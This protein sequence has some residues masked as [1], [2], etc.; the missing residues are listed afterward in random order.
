MRTP[1]PGH[2]NVGSAAWAGGRITVTALWDCT[3][4]WRASFERLWYK[5]PREPR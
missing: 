5:S 3:R 2:L 4:F 1:E